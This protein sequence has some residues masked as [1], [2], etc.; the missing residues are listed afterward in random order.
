[1]FDSQNRRRDR[2]PVMYDLTAD[3]EWGV[4][5]N[6]PLSRWTKR[7]PTRRAFI[8]LACIFVAAVYGV[9]VWNARQHAP[10]PTRDRRPPSHAK[11]PP[12]RGDKKVEKGQEQQH[13]GGGPNWDL[14]E[15]PPLFGE[16]HRAEMT[17]PQHHVA[18]PFANGRKF[19]W[20]ENHVSGISLRG[21]CRVSLLTLCRVGLGWGNYVQDLLMNAQL[22][23]DTGRSYVHLSV[24][25]HEV[26]DA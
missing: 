21:T 4:L 12:Q 19:L 9:R 6:R 17:F 1:M 2:K 14:L 7:K 26:I 24:A 23:Y 13:E 11:P 15:K 22:A 8:L 18:D 10:P 3:S 5:S 25:S 16:Y 20:V